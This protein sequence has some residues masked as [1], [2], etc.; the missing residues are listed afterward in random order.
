MSDRLQIICDGRTYEMDEDAAVDFMCE[1]MKRGE[2][3]NIVHP[4][5]EYVLELTDT[6]KAKLGL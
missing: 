4:E 6:A 3:V 2:R 1:V 5:G